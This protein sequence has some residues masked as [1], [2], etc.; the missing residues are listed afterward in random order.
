MILDFCIW[1]MNGKIQSEN[2]LIFNAKVEEIERK[3]MLRG[4]F[5]ERR[6]VVIVEGCFEWDS[7]K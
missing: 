3:S 7:N 1:G 2:K 6:C 4:Y 5:L